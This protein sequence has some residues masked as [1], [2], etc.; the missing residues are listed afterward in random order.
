MTLWSQD[1]AMKNKMQVVILAGGLA[2]RLGALTLTTPKSMVMVEG[3][4]FLEYQI[5][6]LKSQ[7]I[8]DIVLCIG[9]LGEQI[10]DYFGD[11]KRFGVNL[12]YSIEKTPLGT[13][14]AIKNAQ[15][16]L[17][18]VFVTMYGDSY[19]FLDFNHMLDYFQ[20]NDKLA[21]MTVYKNLNQYDRS[22]TAIEGKLVKKYSKDD[23][24]EA[25][26]YIDYGANVFRREVLEVIPVG[27]FY[28]FER[29]F[30]RLVEANEMLAYEVKERF[31]EIGSPNGLAEFSRFVKESSL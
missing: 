3:K 26:Y 11:G 28:A 19:L 10:Q 27:R 29:L 15:E 7:G 2:T 30:P 23:K 1:I 21:M 22:N 20:S 6:M 8:E 25:M 12:E 14:G 5:E 18:D 17:G 13:A 24:N 9:H 4:P 31:Y 16:L